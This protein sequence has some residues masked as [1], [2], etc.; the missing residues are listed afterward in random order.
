MLWVV[1]CTPLRKPVIDVTENLTDFVDYLCRL[2][3]S[4]RRTQAITRRIDTGTADPIKQQP[5]KQLTQL[6][7]QLNKFVEEGWLAQSIN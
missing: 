2:L 3:T 4:A 5:H 1:F 7:F 6:G